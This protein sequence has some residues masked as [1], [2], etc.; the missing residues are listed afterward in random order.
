MQ[1]MFATMVAAAALMGALGSVAH[2]DYNGGG[3][4]TKGKMCWT[5]TTSRDDGM[6]VACPKPSKPTKMSKKMKM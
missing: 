4:V 5:A 2:A 6:W 1:K 3:M